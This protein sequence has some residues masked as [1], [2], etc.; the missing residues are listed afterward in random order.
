MTMPPIGPVRDA[1]MVVKISRG[2]VTTGVPGMGIVNP[3]STTASAAPPNAA[4]TPTWRAER[5]GRF[6]PSTLDVTDITASSWMCLILKD[7]PATA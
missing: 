6:S 1:P 7:N 4:A 3:A 5:S 2:S